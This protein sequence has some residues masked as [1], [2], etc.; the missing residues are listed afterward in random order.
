M[1]L[2]FLKK[3]STEK[4]TAVKWTGLN[5]QEITDFCDEAALVKIESEIGEYFGYSIPTHTGNAIAKPGDFIVK[6][7]KHG[8]D[9]FE[10]WPEEKL[11]ESY[12]STDDINR[13]LFDI[14]KETVAEKLNK[15]N[16]YISNPS[17]KAPYKLLDTVEQGFLLSEKDILESYLRTL[18]T[19][20]SYKYNDQNIEIVTPNKS[21]VESTINLNSGNNFIVKI[22]GQSGKCAAELFIYVEE[23]GISLAKALRYDATIKDLII[24]LGDYFDLEDDWYTLFGLDEEYLTTKIQD[25]EEIDI[26]EFSYKYQTPTNPDSDPDNQGD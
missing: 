17:K 24:D 19:Y 26:K 7:N 21:N 22:S 10:V 12:F 14:E 23:T 5:K 25:I 15:L 2:T 13:A 18:L 11:N 1:E 8:Q 3:P 4:I 6:L 20:A 16:K 9:V